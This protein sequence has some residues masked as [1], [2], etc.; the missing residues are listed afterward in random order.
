MSDYSN[1]ECKHGT[2]L[3]TPDS[4]VECRADLDALLSN[5]SA[6]DMEIE[7]LQ[8]RVKELEG[9]LIGK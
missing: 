4:C 6:K 1:R 8:A 3:G 7:R 5:P 2:Y 9:A